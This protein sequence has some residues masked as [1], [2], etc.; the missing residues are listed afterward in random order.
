MCLFLL[1][2]FLFINTPAVQFKVQYEMRA[3]C[4]HVQ[5]FEHTGIKLLLWC[6]S[7]LIFPSYA[8]G[9]ISFSS[10]TAEVTL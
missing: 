8:T 9:K 1:T 7:N 4:L 2:I 3:Y 5:I 6:S 10:T